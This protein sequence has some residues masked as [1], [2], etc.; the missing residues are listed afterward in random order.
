M[1]YA[2]GLSFYRGW[3]QFRWYLTERERSVVT[4]RGRGKTVCARGAWWV[5][6]R[7]PSTT[8]LEVTSGNAA[9]RRIKDPLLRSTSRELSRKGHCSPAKRLRFA[10]SSARAAGRGFDGGS[11]ARQ[12]SLARQQSHLWRCTPGAGCLCSQRR[13]RAHSETMSSSVAAVPP[14]AHSGGL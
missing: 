8:P 12:R 1:G 11:S 9:Q 2:F 4:R 10:S 3:S 7:G 14:H 13:G 5:L 6:L